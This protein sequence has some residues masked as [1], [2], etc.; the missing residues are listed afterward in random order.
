[1]RNS[2]TVIL[3]ALGVCQGDNS[4]KPILTKSIMEMS[5]TAA[6]LSDL[7]YKNCSTEKHDFCP[8]VGPGHEFVFYKDYDDDE[9]DSAIVVE[10]V[11][12]ICYGIFRGTQGT[13]D[14]LQN[15]D[16]RTSEVCDNKGNCCESRKGFVDGY[17]TPY[18]DEFENDLRNCAAKCPNKD[19]CVVLGGHSQGGAVATVASVR[20]RDL[21]PFV[22]TFG[23]PPAVLAPCDS[24]DAKKSYRYINSV[25]DE[26]ELEHDPVPF[27]PS[28]GAGDFGYMI[29]VSYENYAVASYGLDTNALS[30]VSQFKLNVKPFLAHTIR[31]GILGYVERINA[32]IDFNHYP[33][34]TNGWAVG[35]FCNN[36]EECESGRCADGICSEVVGSC[37]SCSQDFDCKSG[38]CVSGACTRLDGLVDN[39]C[40]CDWSS[41]CL[42]GRCEGTFGGKCHAKLP[43]GKSCNEDSDC[44]SEECS[45]SFR[46][47]S[48][49][50]RSRMRLNML[51]ETNDVVHMGERSENNAVALSDKS[52]NVSFYG[53]LLLAT[54]FTVIGFASRN[55]FQRSYEEIPVLD[56]D[57]M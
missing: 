44:I 15:V 32:I 29:V 55:V 37:E 43:G 39:N 35:D 12:G 25:M 10:T 22:F 17:N 27:S 51:S 18:K 11:D 34:E 52:E 1:M 21:D 30:M 45:W 5:Y 36:G 6:V 8:E 9:D 31:D 49:S 28:L 46:C 7:A 47:T 40:P 53:I 19:K 54:L 57:C 42:E 50:S 20:L 56:Y 4:S 13:A 16:P 24:I 41:E 14:W 48:E 26:D 33:V 3:L 23:Q 2:C 38:S